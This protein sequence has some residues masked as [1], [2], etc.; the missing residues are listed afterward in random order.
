[1]TKVAAIIPAVAGLSAPAALGIGAA[2]TA[3]GALLDSY[4][5]RQH[6]ARQNEAN[7]RWVDFQ[8]QQT[9]RFDEQDRALRAQSADALEGVL[10]Q[11]DQGSREAVIDAETERLT[12]NFGAEN[13]PQVADGIRGSGQGAGTSKVF[14]AEMARQLGNATRDAR[15]RIEALARATS[16]GGGSMGGMGMTDAL[17]SATAAAN[18]GAFGD[19]RRGNAGIL[20][21]YSTIEPEILTYEQSPL[22]PLLNT[23]GSFFLGGGP[24]TLA[25]MFP[26]M[27]PA[28]PATSIRPQARP[29]SLN[30][31]T[32]GGALRPQARPSAGF[33]PFTPG[34]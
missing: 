17:N 3:G 4:G 15:E 29:S 18:I 19:Q 22:V 6:V 1:M 9:Q 28:A 7:Q 10:S 31:T 2:L 33:S 13:L 21:R 20:Q 14:D 11:A 30:I 12:E 5:Q 32:P 23:A 8:R 25:G 16:Y 24:Q 34:P 27:M 26:G